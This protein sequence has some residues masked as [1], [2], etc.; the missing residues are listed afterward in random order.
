MTVTSDELDFNLV[1]ELDGPVGRE[2]LPQALG[3]RIA[4]RVDTF[5][6]VVPDRPVYHVDGCHRCGFDTAAL[7]DPPSSSGCA[8]RIFELGLEHLHM[9]QGIG[10]LLLEVLVALSGR[11]LVV[12]LRGVTVRTKPR[13]RQPRDELGS[14]LIQGPRVR[15]LVADIVERSGER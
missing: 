10:E 2:E 1:V 15:N 13:W 4:E 6:D 8:V 14:P 9:R 11:Y 7:Y 5:C 12:L 3:D